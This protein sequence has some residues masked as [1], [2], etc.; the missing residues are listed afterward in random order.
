VQANHLQRVRSILL[1]TGQE[2]VFHLVSCADS[3]AAGSV[4]VE[5]PSKAD[6]GGNG[7]ASVDIG[8][9]ESKLSDVVKGVAKPKLAATNSSGSASKPMMNGPSSGGSS[10][11]SAPAPAAPNSS[12][13]TAAAALTK[14]PA[15]NSS[16]PLPN[17]DLAQST[18]ALTPPTSPGKKEKS[19]PAPN[20]PHVKSSKKPQSPQPTPTE[21]VDLAKSSAVV[22]GA[23]APSQ[24]P[25]LSYAKMAQQNKERLEQLARE[26]KERELEQERE[27][28]REL[29]A[30]RASQ[31]S[32]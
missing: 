22:A 10:N 9:W 29:A 1:F 15:E 21:S 23:G 13:S 4:S 6:D 3:G 18:L 8:A 28:K 11:S 17:G 27:R 31:A 30:V 32:K 7:S 20:A 25:S 14:T 2:V 19:F 5:A 12:S 16:C 24:P 26:V